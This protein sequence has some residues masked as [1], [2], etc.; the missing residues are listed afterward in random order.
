MTAIT[1]IVRKI[2]TTG[3]GVSPGMI[4]ANAHHAEAQE[5]PSSIISILVVIF[6]CF[7]V[8]ICVPRTANK[9]VEA[10][11]IKFLVEVGVLR[12]VPHLGVRHTD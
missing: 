3:N 6:R 12:A 11:A 5:A 9:S 1:P 4:V 8:V 2:G 7:L 10:T